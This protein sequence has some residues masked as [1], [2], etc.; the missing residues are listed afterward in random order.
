MKRQSKLGLIT[1]V[2]LLNVLLLSAC[3]GGNN[4]VAPTAAGNEKQ[5]DSSENKGNGEPVKLTFWGGVPAEAGPQEVVDNWNKENP[6][7]QVEYVRYVNDDAGNLKL[8]TALMTGQGVDLYAS[9]LLPRLENRVQAGNAVDLAQFGDYDIDDKIGPDAKAWQVEGKYYAMPTKKNVYFMWL[10][11]DALDAADLPVPYDWTWEDVKDYAKQ[12]GT[13]DRWGMVQTL[14]ELDFI[15]DGS[16][17]AKGN[18][19]T[20]GTSNLGDPNARRY[21]EILHEMMFE[22]KTTPPMGEQISNK[23]PIEA[24]FLGG[25]AAMFYAGEWIF[26]FA[27]NLKDYPRDFKIAFAPI[28][29]VTDGQGDFKTIGGVG[30]AISINANSKNV[31]AAWKFL[32]WYADGGMLPQA[33]GGRL[34]ASKDADGELA[35]EL[36]LKGVEDTYDLDSVKKVLLRDDLEKFTLNLEQ[37]VIDMRKEEYEKYFT[38]AQSLDDTVAN[39]VKRH[40]DFIKQSK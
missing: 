14:R 35:L 2:L 38:H 27:N 25:K 7:I 12:L 33:A 31:E 32:K 3:M 37:Q 17:A 24:D 15:M 16:T 4:G 36:L 13:N 20:D 29:K 23:M 40:N 28:P 10:N 6:D 19:L 21:L 22:D 30:D 39:I 9:Y 26:R 11:K 34:P 5:S 1:L 18:I 8:D